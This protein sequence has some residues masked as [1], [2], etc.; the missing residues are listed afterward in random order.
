LGFLG[1]WDLGFEIWDL[2]F[3]LVYC[4]AR[5]GQTTPWFSFVTLASPL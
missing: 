2:G 4:V 1:A 3:F 5:V